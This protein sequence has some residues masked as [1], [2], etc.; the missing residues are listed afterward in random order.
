MYND[1]TFIMPLKFF[2]PDKTYISINLITR[3]LIMKLE[4]QRLIEVNIHRNI[5]II[6]SFN[7]QECPSFEGNRPLVLLL[8]TAVTL[9]LTL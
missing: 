9:T 1:N 4:I 3:S 5:N 8:L 7:K 2:P 6:N